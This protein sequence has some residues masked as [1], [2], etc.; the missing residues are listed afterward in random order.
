MTIQIYGLSNC[1]TCK[2]ACAWLDENGISY[3]FTDYREYPI[4]PQL[5]QTWAETSSWPK[6][7]NRASMTWRNLP[8]TQKNPANDKDWLTLI[9]A[10]PTLIRRPVT[11]KDGQ[12]DF[13]F[14]EKLYT[15]KFL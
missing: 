14:K 6:V 12:A 11:V 2:K 9:E 13:G 8:E 15:Q 1:S 4:D 7:I 10:Y 5:L 3:H